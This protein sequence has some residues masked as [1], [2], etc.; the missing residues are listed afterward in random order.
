[1]KSIFKREYNDTYNT[2]Q[3]KTTTYSSEYNLN[4]SNY[5]SQEFNTYNEKTTKNPSFL[6]VFG[7]KILS[8]IIAFV[9]GIAAISLITNTPNLVDKISI[10]ENFINFQLN[11]KENKDY[12]DIKIRYYLK[13]DPS[14]KTNLLLNLTNDLNDIKIEDLDFNSSYI[15]EITK[16]DEVIEQ[17]EF[18][19]KIPF[20]KFLIF[21]SRRPNVFIQLKDKLTKEYF[22]TKYFE[23]KIIE[24][25]IKKI[26]KN[27]FQYTL[28]DNHQYDK[29]VIFTKDS[30]NKNKNIF[31]I[32]TSS[33]DKSSSLSFELT[34]QLLIKNNFSNNYKLDIEIL[35]DNQIIKKETLTEK[36]NI[37]YF[38]PEKDTF[39]KLCTIKIYDQSLNVTT[40][41]IF[42]FVAKEE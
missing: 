26:E 34:D 8:A 10:N 22:I 4:T 33:K 28:Y 40:K 35:I 18:K 17:K 30:N 29:L 16:K 27:V 14:T 32:D 21:D 3:T 2:K 6:D 12:Q 41:G 15:V 37:L 39:N 23:D 7:G 36:N 24:E 38:K 5:N 25:S 1:M 9:T 19:T 13:S 31:E 11:L 42:M 20:E